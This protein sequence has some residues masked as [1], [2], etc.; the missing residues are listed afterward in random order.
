M[1]APANLSDAAFR[2][3]VVGAGEVAALFDASPWLTRFELWQ[4]KAGNIAAPEFNAIGADGKP[5]D[6]RIFCGVMLEQAVIDIACKLWGYERVETPKHVT[7]G[8]GL[9]GHP[10]QLV[11]CPERGVGVLEIKTADW[12]IAKQWGDEPP[13]NYQL[14]AQTYAGLC[15]VQ[16]CDIIT[17]VGGNE[18]K[19]FQM[20]FR[21]KV[22]AEIERR[23]AEFWASVEAGT[24][25]KPDYTRDGG[26]LAELYS[27]P[28]NTLADL[29][30]DNRMPELLQEYLDAKDAERAAMARVDAAKAE[31]LEKLGEH[32]AAIVEGY[33]CRV[34]LQAG[35]PDRVIT[36]DMVGQVLPGRKPHRR[37]YVKAKV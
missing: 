19:R 9:G 11:R 1:N 32:S 3:S 8:K 24:A 27:D 23:V 35:S 6:M 16:W 25:P 37:F 15:G 33:S 18:P 28:K 13:L 29:R 20:E 36:A 14:Q 26:A 12:L 30:T 10:D 2:A 31:I 5:A 22:F 17:L 4:R 21:G 34:P 7:N